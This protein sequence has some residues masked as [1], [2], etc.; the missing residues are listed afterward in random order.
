[1]NVVRMLKRKLKRKLRESMDPYP[2]HDRVDMNKV[3]TCLYNRKQKSIKFVNITDSLLT[4]N[5]FVFVLVSAFI[6][7]FL[8]PFS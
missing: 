4:K 5:I 1:M 2:K 6:I 8:S 3:Y 7:N